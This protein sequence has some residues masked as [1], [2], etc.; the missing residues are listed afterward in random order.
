MTTRPAATPAKQIRQHPHNIAPQIPQNLLH[1]SEDAATIPKQTTEKSGKTDSDN[2]E[3]NELCK[4]D[5][6]AQLDA[7]LVVGLHDVVEGI[8]PV[9]F[10][11]VNMGEIVRWWHEDSKDEMVDGE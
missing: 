2:Q 9:R 4:H 6:V 5:E 10:D 1:Q 8:E 3:E 11:V 7:V